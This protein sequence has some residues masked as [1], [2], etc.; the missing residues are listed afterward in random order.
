MDKLLTEKVIGRSGKNV[1]KVLFPQLVDKISQAR[2]IVFLD[3]LGIDDQD[4]TKARGVRGK[5]RGGRQKAGEITEMQI[6]MQMENGNVFDGVLLRSDCKE[7]DETFVEKISE[8][9]SSFL[10]A[11]TCMYHTTSKPLQY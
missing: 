3:E 8:R 11:L 6:N 5:V 1:S 2:Y 9:L 10:E 4:E 7:I